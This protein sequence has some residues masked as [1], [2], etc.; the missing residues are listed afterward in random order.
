MLN[1]ENETPIAIRSKTNK[2]GQY[3][4]PAF[5][6]TYGK[7]Y[8]SYFK[9]VNI[10]MQSPI[11]TQQSIQAKHY[12]LQSNGSAKEKGVAAQ[13]LYDIYSTQSYTCEVEMM[14]CA[15]IQPLMYFVL[16][17]IPMFRG[18]YMIFKVHHSIQPGNMTTTFSGCRMA[19]V[20]NKIVE[21]IFTDSDSLDDSL[22]YSSETLR[23]KKLILTI[24]A[25]IKLILFMKKIY[26]VLNGKLMSKDLNSHQKRHGQQPCFMLIYPQVLV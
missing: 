15:W 16:L 12:I 9:R 11:A 19:N 22:S 8:Q 1:D 20:S 6:V 21:D 24:T 18:S 4:I 25:N 2:E 23:Q 10:N 26:Q 14:G 5:G 17:N 13:D 7:Q 3:M